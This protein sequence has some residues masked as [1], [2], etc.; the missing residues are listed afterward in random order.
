MSASSSSAAQAAEGEELSI[1][2]T[3]ERDHAM[4]T[5]E[6]GNTNLDTALDIRCLIWEQLPTSHKLEVISSNRAITT[7]P[8]K[9]TYLLEKKEMQIAA[10]SREINQE[11]EEFLTK[12]TKPW[13]IVAEDIPADSVPDRKTVVGAYYFRNVYDAMRDSIT[14]VVGIALQDSVFD[15][16]K[17]TMQNIKSTLAQRKLYD[18]SA[19]PFT[20]DLGDRLDE[21]TAQ[22]VLQTAQYLK[23]IEQQK[24]LQ[25]FILVKICVN[26]L[27]LARGMLNQADWS[28]G[29]W[30]L[31]LENLRRKLPNHRPKVMVYLQAGPGSQG[32]A[33]CSVL[34]SWKESGPEANSSCVFYGG[35]VSKEEYEVEWVG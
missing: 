4:L 11:T 35:E 26:T 7:N 10:V 31:M 17:P 20:M 2:A 33:E 16:A 27:P 21:L 19:S 3:L 30:P 18:S 23:Y 24:D 34:N 22:R 6:A 28:Q 5:N 15:T 8:V 13:K 1:Q 14:N 12:I 25:D 29:R 9:I 32:A